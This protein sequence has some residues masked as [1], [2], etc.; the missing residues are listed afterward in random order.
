VFWRENSG[1]EN[2]LF[3]F[4]FTVSLIPTLSISKF[5]FSSSNSSMESSTVMNPNFNHNHKRP[6]AHDSP[7]PSSSD[8]SPKTISL[9]LKHFDVPLLSSAQNA[10]VLP[11]DFMRLHTDHP[12]TI[13]RRRR[14][15]SFV[16]RDRR[17]SK[18]HCQLLFDSSLRKL[19]ILNGVLLNDDSTATWR[20]VHEFRKRAR[21]SSQ[22]NNHGFELR[23]ASNGVFVNGVEMEKGTAVEL[24]VEDR[25]SLVCGN[26]NGSCGVGNGVGFVVE[27]IDLEG[28][29]GEIDGL[30]TLSGSQ[31]GKRNRRV[32][33]LKDNVSRYEGV[34]GRGRFLL[35]R[36][37]DILLSNDPVLCVVRDESM[38]APCNAE[39]QSSLGL[40]CESKRVDLDANFGF[41]VADKVRNPKVVLDSSGKENHDPS[42]LGGDCQGKLGSDSD[43]VYPQPGKNF[44]LNRLE[45]MNHGS[46]ACHRSISLPELIHPLESVSRIFIA[47]FTS[48]IKWCDYLKFFNVLLS[49]HIAPFFI[50]CL[51]FLLLS[52][53][54]VLD[55]LAMYPN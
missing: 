49:F 25:V 43:N 26:Q 32:F 1:S 36:C 5:S 55:W 2:S 46:S 20:L 50:S 21:T 40:F 7:S 13:G 38:C 15:C 34:V 28:R 39:V 18:R 42:S 10:V 4:I 9:F 45:F 35:D 51:C 31:S 30:K 24:S 47:T 17:V 6:F 19:Y 8:K 37:R 12:Y 44:Y 14:D 16:F 23:E 33:A 27:R 3:F 11:C 53:A 22:G 54:C 48:D 29:D 52:L 41:D